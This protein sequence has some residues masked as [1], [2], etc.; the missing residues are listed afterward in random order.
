MKYKILPIVYCIRKQT[1]TIVTRLR[2]YL[3]SLLYSTCSL[4]YNTG[5]V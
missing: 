3:S 4:D 5:V 2:L 1:A